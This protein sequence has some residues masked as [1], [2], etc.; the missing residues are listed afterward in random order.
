MDEEKNNLKESL[1]GR[2]RRYFAAGLLV[3]FPLVLSIFIF[4]KI[5]SWMEGTVDIFLNKFTDMYIPGL[6][7]LLLL[8]F[9]TLI[10][11]VTTN[12]IGRRL[13]SVFQKVISRIPLFNKVYRAIQ[14]ISYASLGR[15]KGLFREVVLIEYPRKGIFALGFVTDQTREEISHKLN[16]PCLNLFLPTSPNPTSGMLLIVPKDEVI[17]LSLTVE[18]GF[19]LIVSGGAFTPLKMQEKEI[20]A[21]KKQ[22]HK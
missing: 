5:F 2:I 8:I 18:E 21:D 4:W 13:F 6:G 11:M 3:V 10:G 17:P 9:I 15:S 19:K 20:S 16:K 1:I 14:E 22:G 7:I 12:L